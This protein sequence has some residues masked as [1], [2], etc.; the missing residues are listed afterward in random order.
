MLL[1]R[2]TASIRRPAPNSRRRRRRTAFGLRVDV[3]LSF[4]F[5]AVPLHHS[6]ASAE[7]EPEHFY[8]FWR[9][10]EVDLRRAETLDVLLLFADEIRDHSLREPLSETEH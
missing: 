6:L 5:T 1:N 7:T 3:L 10:A 9:G 4:R 2:P 8:A